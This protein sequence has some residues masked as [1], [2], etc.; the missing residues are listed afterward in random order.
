MAQIPKNPPVQRST[1]ADTGQK[2]VPPLTPG[3]LGKPRS[4]N[5]GVNASDNSPNQGGR[6]ANAGP[7]SK[8]DQGIEPAD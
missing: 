1:P 5:S 8:G 4:G 6:A 3:N 2:S 7:R